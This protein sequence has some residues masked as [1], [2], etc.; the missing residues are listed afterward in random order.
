[1]RINEVESEHILCFSEERIYGKVGER[2]NIIGSG[3][4]TPLAVLYDG[5]SRGP[6]SPSAENEW[7]AAAPFLFTSELK[8]VLAQDDG[9]KAQPNVG[10]GMTS[11]AQATSDF[12][13]LA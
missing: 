7:Q 8:D 1:M 13:M 6:C 3:G 2:V 5:A 11:R 12:C 10:I 9:E 4:Q